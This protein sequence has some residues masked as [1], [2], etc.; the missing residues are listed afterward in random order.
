VNLWQ[1]RNVL[2]ANQ[3][4]LGDT[5]RSILVETPDGQSWWVRSIEIDPEQIVLHAEERES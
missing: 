3:D 1:L 5:H 4:Q 2:V